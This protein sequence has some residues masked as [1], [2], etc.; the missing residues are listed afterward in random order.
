MSHIFEIKVDTTNEPVYVS[1]AESKREK[2]D[3]KFLASHPS[4]GNAIAKYKAQ[5]VKVKA[6]VKVEAEVKA[7]VKVND[8]KAKVKAEEEVKVKAEEVKAKAE[9]VK[10]K[11]KNYLEAK[12]NVT[13]VV[14]VQPGKKWF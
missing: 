1:P 9:E 8:V 7:E 12:E 13:T 4:I 2:K 14:R 10:A 11:A 5:L 3:K 6:E